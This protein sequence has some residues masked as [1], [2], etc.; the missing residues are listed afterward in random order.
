MGLQCPVD[1]N[2]RQFLVDL[3]TKRDK[4]AAVGIQIEEK[5]YQSTIIQS[6]PKYLASFAS[7]QL[8]TTRLYSPTQ[9]IDP[10]ILISL[11]IEESECHNR[12]ETRN[13]RSKQKARDGDEALAVAPGSFSSQG[14]GN[15][16]DGRRGGSS[17][18]PACQRGPCWNCGSRDH[19]KSRCPK[20]DKSASQSTTDD[21]KKDSANAATFDSKE[22]GAFSMV[23]WGDLDDEFSVPDLLS[24]SSDGDNEERWNYVPSEEER[25]SEMGD[26][27]DGEILPPG[28]DTF[29]DI[30]AKPSPDL[31]N[32]VH[33]GQ[34]SPPRC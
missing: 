23:A 16:R 3:R 32:L 19:F 6:L 7:G 24:E 17:A 13:L 12:K 1:G 9:M 21:A 10:D 25:F 14:Q 31:M 28:D 8:A 29:S 4:L 26:T 11:I 34:I 2:V 18:G 15:W 27:D 20:P 33:D 22:E 30:S 5:D